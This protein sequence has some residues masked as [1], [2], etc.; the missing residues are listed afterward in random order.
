MVSATNDQS[1]PI[2]LG[3]K[4]EQV[5]KAKNYTLLLRFRFKRVL[6]SLLNLQ[7]PKVRKPERVEVKLFT[8]SLKIQVKLPHIG[9][10]DGHF[11]SA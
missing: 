10:K 5:S 6:L 4:E 2:S 8:S 7:S 3:L 1:G 11:V 9:C